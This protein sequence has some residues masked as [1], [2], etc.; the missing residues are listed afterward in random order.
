M[1]AKVWGICPAS[2]VPPTSSSVVVEVDIFCQDADKKVMVPSK[3]KDLWP[4]PKTAGSRGRGAAGRPQDGQI[5]T[6]GTRK[7]GVTGKKCCTGGG[8]VPAVVCK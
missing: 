6:A 8:V 5:A 3:W 2:L 7:V 1:Q 4:V